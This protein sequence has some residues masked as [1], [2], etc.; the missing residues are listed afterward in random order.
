MTGFGR[1][2]GA[3]L[4]FSDRDPSRAT[5]TTAAALSA[6]CALCLSAA[7]RHERARAGE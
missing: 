5:A 4:P 2:R 3:L 1:A 6:S 7:L